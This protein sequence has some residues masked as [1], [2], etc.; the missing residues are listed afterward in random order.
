MLILKAI[1]WV[2][3]RLPVIAAR[4][5]LMPGLIFTAL[6]AGR[7]CDAAREGA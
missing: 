4:T 5:A 3:L 7:C 6:T 2:L 1:V